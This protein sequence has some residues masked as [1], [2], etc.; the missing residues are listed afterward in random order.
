[1]RSPTITDAKLQHS[2]PGDFTFHPHHLQNPASQIA[3]R[4]SSHHATQNGPLPR[5]M[6]Q[7]P[8]AQGP[9][10]HFEVPNST[11]QPG[12]QMF[13]RAQVG[14]QMGQVPFLGN[15]TGPALPPSLPAF[16]NAS[17][18]GQPFMQMG[19]RSLSS[20]PHIPYLTGPLPPRPGNP[21]QL[22]QNYPAPVAPQGQSFALN[23]QPFMSLAS[24]RPASF[25]GGLQVYDPFSPTSVSNASQRKG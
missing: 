22:Q 13:S 9:P 5:P 10:F 12:R 20:T 4:P 1:M 3:A 25:H 11:P 15:P 24:A 16:A 6:M 8:T 14:Y 19:S 2:G 21:L 7:S 23:Q 18:V 17:S